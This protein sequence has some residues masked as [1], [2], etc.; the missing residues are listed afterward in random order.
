MA[1]KAI[2]G[3]LIRVTDADLTEG[4]GELLLTIDPVRAKTISLENTYI[5]LDVTTAQTYNLTLPSIASLGGFLN[6]TIYITDIKG[7]IDS[8]N[9]LTIKVDP[10]SG[11]TIGG[12][13]EVAVVGRFSG[14]YLTPMSSKQWGTFYT[15][16]VSSKLAAV[17]SDEEIPLFKPKAP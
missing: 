3:S 13:E 1:S 14:M 17:S 15:Q 11:D 8:T 16:N 4:S 5:E 12:Q 7:T 10:S 2:K 9:K 6:S